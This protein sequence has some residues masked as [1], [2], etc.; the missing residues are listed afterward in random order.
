L[1]EQDSASSHTPCRTVESDF[2]PT[3]VCGNHPEYT[4]Y[5]DLSVYK[6]EPGPVLSSPTSIGPVSQPKLGPH[7]SSS[8]PRPSPRRLFPGLTP[9]LPISLRTQP[10]LDSVVLC[11][12]RPEY[13][14]SANSQPHA[15]SHSPPPS[16]PSPPCFF[17]PAA[18]APQCRVSSRAVAFT[19]TVTLSVVARHL[20]R[21]PLHSPL[22]CFH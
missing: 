2:S 1:V 6:V 8:T 7:H 5:S 17:S 14:T 13:S 3:S 10:A 15:V 4:L 19:F 18:V 9:S 11:N 16:P 22:P 20:S 12:K 21:A